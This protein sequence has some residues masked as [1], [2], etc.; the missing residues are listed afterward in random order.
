MLLKMKNKDDMYCPYC[1]RK[2]KMN[3]GITYRLKKYGETDVKCLGC[4][5]DFSVQKSSFQGCEDE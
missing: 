2:W 5:R 1:N 3:K 4:K